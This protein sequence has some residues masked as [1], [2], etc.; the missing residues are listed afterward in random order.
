MKISYAL[1]A[2]GLMCSS[3]AFAITPDAEGLYRIGNATDLEE[4]A[5][6]VNSGQANING[7]LTAD[8]DMTGVIHAAI[9]NQEN[10]YRGKW[11]GRFHKISNLSMV[12]EAG[13]NLAL[14]GVVA[15]GAKISNTILDESCEFSG[16]DKI[17]GFVGQGKA[18]VECVI[19]FT[20]LGF[21]GTVYANGTTGSCRAAAIAGPQNENVSYKFVNCYN[22]GSVAGVPSSASVGAM[23]TCSPRSQVVNCF[24]TTTIKRGITETKPDGGNPSPVGHVLIDLGGEAIASPGPWKFSSFFGSSN[25]YYSN[26]VDGSKSWKTPFTLPTTAANDV[27]VYKIVE[28]SWS[29]TGQLCWYLN[30]N[31]LGTKSEDKPCWGQNL[32]EGDSYPSFLPGKKVVTYDGTAFKNTTDTLPGLPDLPDLPAGIDS[33]M[34]ENGVQ[35]VFNMQG[36]EVKSATTPGLYIIN[37]KKVIVK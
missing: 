35:K 1:L 30:N 6:L 24:T 11:D 3:A 28:D 14:F 19:E 21:E 10:P 34:G 5:A 37:G 16:A 32:D 18:A 36:V 29:P 4:F 15:D 12:N 25:S 9:G 33:P 20:C 26:V 22:T 8:I 13:V 31:T 17:A 27:Y 23:A 2:A 7:V